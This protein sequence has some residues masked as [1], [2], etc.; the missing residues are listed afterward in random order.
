MTA[1]DVRAPLHVR[2]AN[3]LKG[4]SIEERLLSLRAASERSRHDSGLGCERLT[5]WRS[6]R[7]LKGPFVLVDPETLHHASEDE[8][9]VVLGEPVEAVRDRTPPP[10]WLLVLAEAFADSTVPI[11]RLELFDSG[12]GVEFL[13]AVER[14]VACAKERVRGRAAAIRRADPE[15]PFEPVDV[16]DVLFEP[17]VP[18]LSR[19]LVRPL[20]LELHAARLTGRLYGSTAEERFASFVAGLRERETCLELLR[21]YPVLARLVTTT[22]VDWAEAS[23]EFLERIAADWD[24]LRSTF[25]LASGDRVARINV[26]GDRHRGGRAVIAVTFASGRKVVYKPKSTS[27]EAHFREFVEW[28]DARSGLPPSRR[29]AVLPRGD[30]G[31]S[32]FVEPAPCRTRDEL[33][34][35]YRRQGSH[36][37]LLYVLAASDF[38]FENV[39]A[40]ADSPVLVDF[41]CLFQ[42]FPAGAPDGLLGAELLAWETT[43][44]SVLGVGMLPRPDLI[45]AESDAADVSGLG[46]VP[47]QLMPIRLPEWERSGTDEMHQVLRYSPMRDMQHTPLA[48]DDGD[49]SV[50][51][52]VDDVVT[53]FAETYRVL[54]RH[55][56]EL[57]GENGPIRP[58]ADDEVRVILRPTLDYGLLLESSLH[59]HFVRDGVEHDRRFDRLLG[60]E[61]PW[62]EA[63]VADAERSSLWRGDIPLFVSRPASRDLWTDEGTRIESFFG[64]SGFEIVQRRV[65]GL[66]QADLERQSWLVRMSIASAGLTPDTIE[67]AN[68]ERVPVSRPAAR[69]RLVVA[70]QAVGDRLDE[71]ALRADGEATWLGVRSRQG[72]RWRIDPVGL[73]LYSGLA[74]ICLFLSY[75]AQ[76]SGCERYRD[77]ARAAYPPLRRQIERELPRLSPGGYDGTGGLIY[78]LAHLGTLWND[79]GPL[80]DAKRLLDAV[81]AAVREHPS[82]DVISGAAGCVG[83]LI[84]VRELL[85]ADSLATALSACGEQLLATALETRHGIGWPPPRP[86]WKP[87]GGF[88]HGAAG[89][90][91]ALL[92]L[93]AVTREARFRAAALGAI[94]YQR[95]LFSPEARNWRDLRQPEEKLAGS[96]SEDGS[97]MGHWCNGASGVALAWLACARHVDDPRLREDAAI[98]VATTEETG[99]GFNHCL[100]HGDLGNLEVLDHAA[101]ADIGGFTRARTRA[102]AAEVLESIAKRG[103]LTGYPLGLEAPGLM[104]GLAGIGYGLLRLAD[105]EHVPSVLLLQPPTRGRGA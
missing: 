59:P 86:G 74:G 14:P 30:Y 16:A 17:L 9:L 97:F 38:H 104:M 21:E 103:W 55:R 105:P 10:W 73:D 46:A 70:A 72:A 56:D 75:L 34:R 95:S 32:E 36:I 13:V 43:V 57:R 23:I 8:L 92:E 4:L 44:H 66:S 54:W 93:A 100:C 102:L 67:Y 45:G 77:L 53:G 87:L 96:A 83:A 39:I 6:E 98:A 18:R 35:F 58:F 51:D 84:A 63:G 85:P 69:D 79:P 24:R 91:W 42:P 50:R 3:W 48:T 60:V 62:V 89:I 26:L 37:A 101:R 25:R 81:P 7:P 78:A 90:G 22:L 28:V 65:E 29:V 20:V 33:R 15:V 19:F 88:A 68:S 31:W 5:R 2:D 41:E 99:L 64:H 12:P 94:E 1:V 49:V 61:P 76:Q 11:Q 71:L 82:A 40:S 80:E 52:F 27:V 47:G